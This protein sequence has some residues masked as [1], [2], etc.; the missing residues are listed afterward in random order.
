MKTLAKFHG[1]CYKYLNGSST[2]ESKYHPTREQFK[3]FYKVKTVSLINFPTM[4]KG[5]YTG[6]VK[7]IVTLLQNRKESP[8]LIDKIKK[9]PAK[10]FNNVQ[11]LHDQMIKVQFT[12]MS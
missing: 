9:F 11:N 3:Q 4:N 10:Y 8:A 1:A 2:D 6:T 12:I 5:M 7:S